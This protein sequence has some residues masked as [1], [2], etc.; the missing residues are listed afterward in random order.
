MS[1]CA[2]ISILLS[3]ATRISCMH[4]MCSMRPLPMATDAVRHLIREGQSHQLHSYL[5]TGA[6]AGMVTMEESVKSL[7]K[8]GLVK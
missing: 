3:T 7:R 2:T 6:K 4:V 1:A 8:M 5:Q